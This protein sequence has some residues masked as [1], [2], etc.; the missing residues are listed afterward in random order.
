MKLP[1]LS[2]AQM[3]GV[4]A[5]LAIDAAALD[6]LTREVYGLS[7]IVGSTARALKLKV[8]EWGLTAVVLHVGA[9]RL[10]RARGGRRLFWA[11]FTAAGLLAVLLLTPPFMRPPVGELKLIGPN[12]YEF[13]EQ[14]PGSLMFRLRWIY[15]SY[16]QHW[17]GR[18][19]DFEL[20]QTILV[21]V[22]ILVFA[23]VGGFV[24]LSVFGRG[25]RVDA[26][27]HPL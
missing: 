1:R 15:G 11:G 4:I 3:M 14:S 9:F 7:P 23:L 27:D 12:H 24:A 10:F 13:I 26:A 6:A 5:V 20:V 19:F 17:G 22:P 18:W 21:F 16:A 8:M 2:L 25:G